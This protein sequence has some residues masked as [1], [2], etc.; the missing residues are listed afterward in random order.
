MLVSPNVVAKLGA[1]RAQGRDAHA[2]PAV[3]DGAPPPPV[4]AP[5]AAP[6]SDGAIAF[7]ATEVSATARGR[8]RSCRSD[9]PEPLAGAP[10][11]SPIPLA[12]NVQ[13]AGRRRQRRGRER[14][15]RPPA[16]PSAAASGA[17]QDLMPRRKPA[18][19]AGHAARLAPARPSAGRRW[20]LLALVVVVGGLGLAVYAFGGTGTDR[21][22]RARSTPA[23]AAL[24]KAH[25]GPRQGHGPGHRPRP[26]RPG[27]A[28]DAPD[29]RLPAARRGRDRPNVSATV[30]DPLR[31]Q[32]VAGLDR[33]Y[34]V[35][36]VAS[37]HA[38]HV[39][40]ATAPR[41]STSAALV[42]GPDG[43]P[44]VLDRATKT[45]YR[46]D[47]KT[48][49]A[50][51]VARAGTKAGGATG[52]TPKFLARRRPGPADPRRRRT[53]CGAGAP[54]NTTGKGTLVKV[55]VQGAARGATT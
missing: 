34:G 23:Q 29:R 47:L 48:K 49:K 5:A 41:R 50:T 10:D 7:E 36:A 28:P 4:R 45:V 11:R 30:V 15:G 33:L 42:R 46:I 39:Q 53:S 40:P 55:P 18:Y 31:A 20:P 17:V 3:G 24:D 14:H 16:G 21:G 2:P 6:G 54:A 38:V 12:D 35:V 52:A 1:G 26:R 37:T 22:H 43:A 9:P 25:D 32:V 19:R 27:Q 8:A 51:L 44:Y 13:A